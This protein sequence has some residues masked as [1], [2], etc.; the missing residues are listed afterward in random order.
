M[1]KKGILSAIGAY[2]LWG[3]F[4]MYWKLL[5]HVP[6][7]QLIAHRVIWSVI[8]LTLIIL[9][10]NRRKEFVEAIRQPKAIWTS[11]L[12]AVLI[13]INWLVYIWGVNAG[14]IVETSLG[15]YIN[16]L[17]SVLLG[18]MFL[19]ERL[20]KYQWLSI[21]IA[22]LGVIYLTVIY[23]RL[24]WI[25][26]SLAFSFGVYGYVKKTAPLNALHGLSLET[27]ILFI[28]ASLFLIFS[29]ITGDGA[30]L[31][32]GYDADL[33]MIGT[34]VATV[35]PLLLFSFAARS[36]PLSTVGIL[37]YIAPTLQL[38]VGVLVFKEPFNQTQWIGFGLVWLALGIYTVEGIVQSRAANGVK[39]VPAIE[40]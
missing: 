31:H 6:A 14:F 10:T 13:A 5:K 22:A 2:L 9:L 26:L 29:E 15:Y 34:G 24:P 27:G 30:F 20:R 1:I 3:I 4:P 16:P 19:R 8:I 23:G 7:R 11:V 21:G 37:Q 28:P 36:I 25:S 12:T 35:V 33:M 18:V 38:L 40:G 32:T 17:V 39:A